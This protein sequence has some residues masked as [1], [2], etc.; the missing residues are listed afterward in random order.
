M[1]LFQFR[2]QILSYQL[3]Q[4]IVPRDT[5]LLLA[6]YDDLD[7]RQLSGHWSHQKLSSAQTGKLCVVEWPEG[8]AP[9]GPDLL[10]DFFKSMDIAPQILVGGMSLVKWATPEWEPALSHV[11]GVAIVN[12]KPIS[13]EP[14]L[15]E[16]ST[17]VT[18]NWRL[19]L[20][21][22]FGGGVV[23]PGALKDFERRFENVKSCH[24]K[25]VEAPK[26]LEALDDFLLHLN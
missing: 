16:P 3:W 10:Q 8:S 15:G 2:N 24:V 4:G 5:L 22:G 11:K 21:E 18:K 12:P 14:H 6:P 19:L 1:A 20:I 13:W 26:V 23:S 7:L 17:H 9:V 25:S